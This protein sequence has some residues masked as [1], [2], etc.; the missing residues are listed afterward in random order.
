[1]E[2]IAITDHA[3]AM[4][5]SPMNWHFCAMDILP[6]YVDGVRVLCGSEANILDLSC[7]IDLSDA[8]LEKL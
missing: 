8:E 4:D 7:A 2:A 1:M 5:D 3:T 6:P